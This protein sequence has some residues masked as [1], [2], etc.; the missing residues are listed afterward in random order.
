M[1]EAQE[2]IVFDVSKKWWHRGDGPSQSRLLNGNDGSMCCIGQACLQWG[3]DPI[4]MLD[5]HTVSQIPTEWPTSVNLV[6]NEFPCFPGSLYEINDEPDDLTDE[7]RIDRLNNE[8]E[9]NHSSF[10]FR[11]VP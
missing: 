8:L 1:A 3:V 10:R 5:M 6:I 11:L 4:D 9:Y 7:E 2:L